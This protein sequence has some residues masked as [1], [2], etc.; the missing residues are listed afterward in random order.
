LPPLGQ[1]RIERSR[2]RSRRSRLLGQVLTVAAAFVL[3][4]STVLMTPPAERSILDG[5]DLATPDSVPPVIYSSAQ[6]ISG[7]NFWSLKRISETG[8]VRDTVRH[9]YQS[10]AIR[11]AIETAF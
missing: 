4:A 3:G 2:G 6:P 11:Q 5:R 8:Q 1:Y 9:E 10:R 7:D